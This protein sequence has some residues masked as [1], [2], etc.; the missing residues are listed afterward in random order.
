MGLDPFTYC[1]TMKELFAMAVLG[2]WDRPKLAHNFVS[3]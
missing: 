1:K 3:Q 2:I